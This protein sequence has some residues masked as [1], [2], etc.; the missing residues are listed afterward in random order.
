MAAFLKG[1]AE[2]LERCAL[3]ADIDGHLLGL[4]GSDNSDMGDYT[5]NVQR[6]YQGRLLAYLRGGPSPVP[7]F[8]G[9]PGAP[10]P[11]YGGPA[12]SSGPVTVRFSAPLLKPAEITLSVE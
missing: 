11:A 5:D 3:A 9:R 10:Q 7:A 2:L 4:E 8:R 6:A 12:P 1:F